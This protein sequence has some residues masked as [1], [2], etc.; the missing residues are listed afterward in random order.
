MSTPQNILGRFDT[1]AYHH[2]L[3]VCNSTDT[4]EALSKTDEI[5]KFQ[6]PRN[7]A[8]YSARDVEGINGGKYVTLIDGTTDARFYITSARWSNVIAAE[9]HIG[10]GNIP[11]STTMS[12]DGELEIVEPLGAS[13]LNRLTDICDEL[14]TDPVGLIFLLKTRR[15]PRRILPT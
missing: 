8:R 11:Q 6:H 5:T 14:D 4:A 10:K 12:T 7:Q 13:F 9:P 2:I 3:M 15:S 1:Y